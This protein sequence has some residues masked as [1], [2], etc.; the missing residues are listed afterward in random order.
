VIVDNDLLGR[1]A[2]GFRGHRLNAR[3]AWLPIQISH[4]SLRKCTVQ[5]IGSLVAWARNG[6]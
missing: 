4:A 3:T 5:F 1:Q 6:T 2:C